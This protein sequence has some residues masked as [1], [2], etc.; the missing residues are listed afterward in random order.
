MPQP[1]DAGR[2][3]GRT[4]GEH[5]PGC[6]S[7]TILS[8]AFPGSQQYAGVNAVTAAAP[9]GY[10]SVTVTIPGSRPAGSYPVIVRACGGNLGVEL[11]LTIT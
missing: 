8:N 7:V 10:F 2:R 9:G 1:G 6:N 3:L 5:A 4:V 11:L